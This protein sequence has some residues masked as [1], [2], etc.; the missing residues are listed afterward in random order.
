MGQLLEAVNVWNK[1]VQKYGE[2]NLIEPE[3][4]ESL[5]PNFVWTSWSRGDDYLTPGYGTGIEACNYFQTPIEWTEDDDLKVIPVL[6]WV[7][8]PTCS[9]SGDDD[10]EECNGHGSLYVDIPESSHLTTELEIFE[11]REAY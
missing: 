6:I 9:S 4:A 1:Y 7:D 2:P 10:C 11:K 5:K 8:C 3:V